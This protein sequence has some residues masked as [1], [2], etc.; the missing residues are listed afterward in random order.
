MMCCDGACDRR[1][2]VTRSGEQWSGEQLLTRS[3]VR[4]AS[5]ALRPPSPSGC[6][7]RRAMRLSLV[8]LMVAIAVCLCGSAEAARAR[9]Q[10]VLAPMPGLPQ[11]SERLTALTEDDT[12]ASEAIDAER[13]SLLETASDSE[14]ESVSYAG[15]LVDVAA[16]NEMDADAD[17]EASAALDSVLDD[18]NP[19]ADLNPNAKFIPV[20]K[21]SLHNELNDGAQQERVR[22]ESRAA[23]HA[24]SVS[25]V[26]SLF[27]SI[28]QHTP[29]AA[30]QVDSDAE[31]YMSHVF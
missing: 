6:P 9:S 14:S 30:A 16:V 19:D 28:G 27:D 11:M 3:C 8:L 22:I 31:K 23:P 4:C 24:S 20:I 13:P 7:P 5:A 25:S 1:A 29:E 21:G 2:V 15:D 26:R 10:S 18:S 12:L 17:E